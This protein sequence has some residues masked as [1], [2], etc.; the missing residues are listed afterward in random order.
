VIRRG[1][2]VDH[3]SVGFSELILT[4][5]WYLRWERRQLVHGEN[6]QRP[7][8]SGLS[9]ATLTKNYKMATIK[10]TKERQGWHKPSEKFVKVNI[11]ASFDEGT[12]SGSTVVIIRYWTGGAIAA[13]H[14]FLLYLVDAPMAKAFALKEGLLLAQHAGCNRLIVQS[15]CMEVVEIMANGGF[16]TNSATDVYDEC[17]IVWSGFEMIS[18]EHCSREANKT[19]HELA[20]R[21]MQ[22]KLNCNWM[23]SPLVL[24]LSFL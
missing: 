24:F 12:G 11:D 6:I 2:T 4:G 1:E 5:G 3:L 23:M 14:T 17:N 19:A 18:I 16:S 21:G 15:D 7:S 13:S 22:T 9:I 8:R 20:R 10:G